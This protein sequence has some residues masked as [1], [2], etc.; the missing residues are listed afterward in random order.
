MNRFKNLFLNL[1]LPG[2]ILSGF[3]GFIVGIVIFFYK[4][5]WNLLS[6]GSIKYYEYVSNNH[7]WLIIPSVLIIIVFAFIQAFVIKRVPE[8]RGGGI[9]TSEG[10]VRGS[11]NCNPILTMIGTIFLSFISLFVG[12]PLGNEGPS[13]IVGTTLSSA[14]AKVL[15]EKSRAYKKYIMTGGSSTAFAVATGAPIAGILF[16]LEEIHRKFSPVILLVTMS[17]VICG[18][19]TAHELCNLFNMEFRMFKFFE[20]E[21]IPLNQSFIF[22]LVGLIVGLF[23][24]L[25]SKLTALLKYILEIRT[26]KLHVFFKIL[27]AFLASFVMGLLLIDGIGGGHSVIEK[28]LFENNYGLY[29]L[30]ILFA[31]KFIMISFCNSS[32][33]T[34][35]MFIP[36]LTI[37]AL[38]GAILAK[39]FNME[40]YS[41]LFITA[42][43]VAFMGSSIG[44]PLSAI[45]FASEALSGLTNIIPIILTVF[46]AYAIFK[47][48]GSATLYDIILEAKLKAKY[49]KRDFVVCDFVFTI[50]KDS[51]A[52]FK[53]IRDLLLPAN[54]IILSVQRKN[55]HHFKMDN[56]GD[57]VLLEGDIITLRAQ[58]V[59]IEKTER[60]IKAFFGEQEEIIQNVIQEKNYIKE[61]IKE[62]IKEN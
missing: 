57:K 39:L 13:V 36:I 28:L 62:E 55:K 50:Q 19:I 30:M 26:K 5:L 45:V 27:T 53:A 61:E 18:T 24:V 43:M 1:I 58:T 51:F 47:V 33:V 59:D 7:Y 42:S 9:P 32:G 15:P 44:C 29:A 38:I 54:A 56:L 8:S 25:F 34:G 11:L 21:S 60:E 3:I 41:V 49:T 17:S 22:L 12:V 46:T 48:F 6:A 4:L 35:G 31:V 14:F 52:C 20:I 2:I 37:G 10:I 40:D 23:A 16:A